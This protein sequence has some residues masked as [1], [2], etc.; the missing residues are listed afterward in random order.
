LL[1][2]SEPFRHAIGLQ[3]ANRIRLKRWL[4]SIWGG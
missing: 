1:D 2:F 4:R 3:L